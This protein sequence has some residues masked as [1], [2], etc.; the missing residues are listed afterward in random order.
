MI[1]TF[2]HLD[3]HSTRVS[4]YK[5]FCERDKIYLLYPVGK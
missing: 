1:F 4:N 2:L 5:F 3:Q